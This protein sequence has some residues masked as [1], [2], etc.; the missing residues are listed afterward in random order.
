MDNMNYIL[1]NAYREY[2]QLGTTSWSR[3]R[4]ML[5]KYGRVI[6]QKIQNEDAKSIG[7]V[8]LHV[9]FGACCVESPLFGLCTALSFV[10]TIHFNSTLDWK[11]FDFA[12]RYSLIVG[13]L[14]LHG[15][16]VTHQMG[17]SRY[18]GL[19]G[20]LSRGILALNVLQAAASSLES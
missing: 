12:K 19:S 17:L 5:R 8:A 1:A 9:L 14:V 16:R 18:D 7:Y 4:S 15:S 20:G 11:W 2:A 6:D 10:A 13:S 3:V